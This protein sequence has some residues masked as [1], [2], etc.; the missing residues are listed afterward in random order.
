M[1][2]RKPRRA[3]ATPVEE[4]GEQPS[5]EFV[6]AARQFTVSLPS[7]EGPLDLLLHLIREHKLDIFDIPIAFVTQEYLAYLQRM[8]ELNL[9]VAGEFLVMAATLAHIKSRMLLPRQEEAAD[10]AEEEQGDPREELV[11]R[12]LEYQ[13]YKAAAEDLARQDLLGRDVFT[14]QVK[15]A[16]I[17]LD[18]GDL[19]LKEVSV[20][21]LI[22][23]LDKV[24]RNLKPGK[25]HEVVLER[26]SISDAISR[27]AEL[28]RSQRQVTFFSLF[29]GMTERHRVI[30]TFLGLLE[31]TRLKL[32]RIYQ[33]EVAGDIVIARTDRLGDE[34]IE[35]RDD[36]A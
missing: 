16:E 35:V 11:R 8:K 1:A 13:K 22:E 21:K 31:M 36:F 9:D 18:E 32:V 6:V 25:Q 33:E 3:G 20:F 30:A 2:E 29:D 15:A 5:A 10:E 19:G 26:V 4:A 34:G 14:R 23:A 7:F 12:L 24:L 17:P 28:L 27:I